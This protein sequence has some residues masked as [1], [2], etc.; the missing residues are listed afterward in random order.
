MLQNKCRLYLITPPRIKLSSFID[1]VKKALDGGNVA[2]LQLRL[3]GEDMKAPPDEEIIKAAELLLPICRER[4]VVFIINDRPEV[5][6]QVGADGVH[7]G[8]TQDGTLEQARE[9]VGD[10][11]VIGV[12]CY[13]S[14]DRAMMAGEAGAD[15]V[16]FGAFYPT[17]TKE[18][19]GHPKPDILEWWSTYTN[20]PCV[21]IGGIKPE[22][23]IP[24][25][26][27]GADFI[28][29]VTGVWNHEGGS[30][31]GVKAYNDAIESC[32]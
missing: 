10:N 4:D 29:V 8:E 15:Y 3:K 13:A 26:K 2:V 23:C 20:V 25:V 19:K 28:A 30:A 5:A 21:A 27:A 17:Q 6:K 24:L 14:K 16:A 12:S 7:I 18:P 1:E 31:V 11:M 9:I 22:N 32:Y